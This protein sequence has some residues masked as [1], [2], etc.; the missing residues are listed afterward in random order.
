MK[1]LKT[2]MIIQKLAEKLRNFEMGPSDDFVC[3]YTYLKK[4]NEPRMYLELARET[5]TRETVY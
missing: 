2:L 4:F 3:Q 5:S 1:Q